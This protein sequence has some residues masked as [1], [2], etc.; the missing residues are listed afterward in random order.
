MPEEVRVVTRVMELDGTRN[1][2]SKYHSPI[3]TPVKPH[4]FR[5]GVEGVIC[6]I[7]EP[8]LRS[9]FVFLKRNFFKVTS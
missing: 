1:I 8:K 6:F 7:V 9:L 2:K 4:S 5:D 3:E